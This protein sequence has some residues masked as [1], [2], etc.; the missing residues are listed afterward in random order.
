MIYASISISLSEVINPWSSYTGLVK[1]IRY[2]FTKSYSGIFIDRNWLFD[3]IES[4]LFSFITFFMSRSIA[5]FSKNLLDLWSLTTVI[6]GGDMSSLGERRSPRLRDLVLK[7]VLN[8]SISIL[9]P[10]ALRSSIPELRRSLISYWSFS[11]FN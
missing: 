8:W 9:R 2:S 1:S 5:I 7:A 11:Y 4:F 3:W 6:F 10:W